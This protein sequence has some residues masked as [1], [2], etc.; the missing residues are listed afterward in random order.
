[1]P[2]I[3]LT[4][5]PGGENM[6]KSR[7][8]LVNN[9]DVLASVIN[10]IQDYVDI[11]NLKLTGLETLNVF[12]GDS[13]TSVPNEYLINTNGSILARGN[14]DI[15]G[16]VTAG[17]GKFLTGLELSIGNFVMS[18]ANSVLNL[19]GDFLCGGELVL[20]DF[21]L[22][23]YIPAYSQTYFQNAASSGEKLLITNTLGTANIG[24]K[25]SM[26]GRN[27]LVLDWRNYASGTPSTALYQIELMSS[28]TTNALRIGQIVDVMAK[29]TDTVSVDF[30]VLGT[31]LVYPEYASGAFNVKFTKNYQ[32]M[33]VIWDGTNWV[34]LN[35][36]GAVIEAVV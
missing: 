13:T 21:E 31:T 34:I 28:T 10:E 29:A 23:G 33:R 25:V 1:M 24:G 6:S 17:T 7:L 14:A 8:T 11:D 5:I 4:P 27:S 12:K 35:L 30:Y 18:S 16:K 9:F 15:T 36:E 2:K 19:S 26:K 22:D 20:K 3:K 32:S